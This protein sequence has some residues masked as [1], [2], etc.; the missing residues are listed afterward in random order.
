MSSG[1]VNVSCVCIFRCLLVLSVFHLQVFS[2]S[3][4]FLFESSSIFW[5]IS[6]SCLCFQVYFVSV[7]VSCL[8]V[9]SGSVSSLCLQCLLLLHM[10]LVLVFS[11]FLVLSLL[12]W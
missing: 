2:G 4:R 10:F 9:P 7:N 1:S 3:L 5:L 11:C 8:Q 12:P 6:I